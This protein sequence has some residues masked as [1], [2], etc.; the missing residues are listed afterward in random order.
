MLMHSATHVFVNVFESLIILIR[1][2]YPN[3][4]VYLFIYLFFKLILMSN[5]FI[6]RQ[7]LHAGFFWH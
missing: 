3:P 5:Y 6:N 7:V 1:S 4:Q 2:N